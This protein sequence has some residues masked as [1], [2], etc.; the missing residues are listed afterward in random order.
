MM[1]A[2]HWDSC[3]CLLAVDWLLIND[4]RGS[5]IGGAEPDKQPGETFNLFECLSHIRPP[6]RVQHTGVIC[7]GKG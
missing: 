3:D 7:R 5:L 1:A 2:E 4:V 6:L